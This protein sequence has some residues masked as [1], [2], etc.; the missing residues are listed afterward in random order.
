MRKKRQAATLTIWDELKADPTRPVSDEF[1][2]EHLSRIET[3]LKG[4]FSDSPTSSDWRMVADA[5]NL[6]DTMV[7]PMGICDDSD[8]L[9]ADAGKAM[10]DASGYIK[11]GEPIQWKDGQQNAIKWVVQD[12][13]TMLESLSARTIIRTMRLTEI[14]MLGILSGKR[15]PGDI[16]VDLKGYK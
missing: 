10:F 13:A 8:G 9:I 6:I 11:L 12:Y 5:C 3:G 7:K 16:V 1:K 15:K 2:K 4:L 14:R